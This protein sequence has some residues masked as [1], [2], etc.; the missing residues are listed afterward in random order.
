MREP[1]SHF[2]NFQ[3]I[4]EIIISLLVTET[5]IITYTSTRANAVI[6]YV[7]EK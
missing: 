6:I 3:K 2:I 5:T 4:G 1:Y 7:A